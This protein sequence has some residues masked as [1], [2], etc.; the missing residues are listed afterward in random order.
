LNCN[1]IKK[2]GVKTSDKLVEA[3]E[4][5][6]ELELHPSKKLFRRKPENLL[7]ELQNKKVKS[8]KPE[9]KVA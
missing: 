9:E 3:I 8:N 4:K 5:S 7:P 6:K 2:L 1:K